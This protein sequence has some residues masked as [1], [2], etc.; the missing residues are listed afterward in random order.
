MLEELFKTLIDLSPLCCTLFDAE[1]RCVYFNDEAAQFFKL[2]N[3]YE[4]PENFW[5]LFPEYQH[6]G[7]ASLEEIKKIISDINVSS[8]ITVDWVFRL[9]DG[10]QIP[11]ECTLVR[12]NND[13]SCIFACFSR[14]IREHQQLEKDIKQRD[15][16]FDA[17]NN[18]TTLLL[19]SEVDEFEYALLNSM[20]MMAHAV[21][22]DRVRLWKNHEIE[23][24]LH[25]TQLYE[26]SEGASPQQGTKI[27]VNVSYSDDLPGWEDILSQGHCIN[28]CVHEMPPNGQARLRSQDILSLLIA[29]VFLRDEFWGFVGFN[30]CHR[31]RRFTEDEESILWA[32][33]YLIT[34]ALLRN[35]MTQDLASALEKANA[36]SIAKSEFLSRMSHEIRTPLNAIVG[37]A[38]IAKK[39]IENREKLRDSID[40]ILSASRHLMGLINDVL[41]LSKIESGKLELVS[42]VFSLSSVMQEVASLI[43]SRCLENGITFEANLHTLTNIA[44]KGD[45][46]RLKQVLINLL[47]N[48]VKFTAYGGT[49]HLI[50][51]II[52]QS[53]QN[54]TI[55]FSVRDNGIGMSD[56][57]QSCL[58]IAFEQGD[59]SI[60]AN[61]GGTGLGLA[62]SQNLVHAMGGQ[63]TVESEP[64]KGSTFSFTVTFPK[65]ELPKRQMD[66]TV[67][68]K[69]LNFSGRRMLLAEDIDINRVILVEL[70]KDTGIEIIEAAD[71]RQALQMFEHSKPDYY[72]LIFMDI[73]MP[74]MDGYQTTEAIRKLSRN[75]AKSVPIIAMTANAYREDIEKARESGMDGHLAKPID[76]D[77]VMQLLHDKLSDHW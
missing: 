26:W 39:N 36:A 48:S 43:N 61:Y 46:L 34:N 8:K 38:H 13:D 17:I 56:E 2:R 71:G 23:G 65:A 12:I 44:V 53:Q 72:D 21:D 73:Q 70:L 54:I 28:R 68:I 55:K 29:P 64:G 14:D 63:I 9:Q 49:I 37:M 33:S 24:N 35:E 62:I 47:G 74:Y 25:C 11:A 15:I 4:Y 3:R 30:D 51:E 5:E 7:Q 19:Q 16:L 50:V 27:T 58:F 42:E 22:A 57:Q 45:K 66:M 75:D 41:D 32:G 76:I 67:R 59:S 20:G 18:A 77:A 1:L 31:E 69:N 40:Q 6:D 52:E 10:T 60:A